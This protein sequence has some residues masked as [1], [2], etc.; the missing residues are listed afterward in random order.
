[1]ES[2]G[3]VLQRPHY[4]KCGHT[5]CNRDEDKRW[6][7]VDVRIHG[8]TLQIEVNSE[9]FQNSPMRL[10]QFNKYL[11][12]LQSDLEG[13]WF[14]DEEE[15]D[16][17]NVHRGGESPTQRP[18]LDLSLDGCYEWAVRPFLPLLE[19]IAPRPSDG[20]TITLHHF[21]SGETFDA[22]LKAVDDTLVPG[23][24]EAMDE[25]EN[26]VGN[27]N[28]LWKTTC[29]VF[30]TT[31]VEV[32]SDDPTYI[33][34]DE[35][36]KVRVQ[37]KELFFKAFPDPDD[38]I[39][40]QEV[41]TLEKIFKARLNPQEGRTSYLYGIVEDEKSQ[42]IGLL[43]Y[44]IQVDDTLHD[45]VIDLGSSGSDLKD[46]WKRQVTGT[47]EA[48]HKAGIVWGDVKASNVLV[49]MA[50]DAWVTDF[51]GGHTEGWVDRNKAGTIEGD[52]QGLRAIIEFVD[53]GREPEI[54]D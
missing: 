38:S 29:P 35:P 26:V 22:S 32:L 51:G 6:F 49:D 25:M 23:V 14:S 3:A 1:M 19:E 24:I 52:L 37:G 47:V 53:T 20:T 7:M 13:E 54:M 28:I 4:Q 44:Y 41:L 50:G 2:L 39:G 15:D 34:V 42:A 43:L 46:K 5:P 11:E 10:D 30:A 45:K 40:A 31:E 8:K 48:L 16:D 12:I 21:F 9:E 27:A 36:R 33:L 18:V 17:D